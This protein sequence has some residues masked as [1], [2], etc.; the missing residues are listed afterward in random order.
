[1]GCDHRRGR[2]EQR[3]IGGTATGAEEEPGI[4]W[5]AVWP[6]SSLPKTKVS[7]VAFGRST[8]THTSPLPRPQDKGS[9][10]YQLPETKA[11]QRGSNGMVI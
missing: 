3:V 5:A 11:Y 2:G 7:E 8:Y 6:P 10:P 9:K 1:M 4:F